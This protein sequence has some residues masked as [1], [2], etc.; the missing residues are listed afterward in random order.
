MTKVKFG[1]SEKTTKFD[2]IFVELLT[3]ASSSVYSAHVLNFTATV[4]YSKLILFLSYW[5]LSVFNWVLCY[6]KFQKSQH[7]VTDIKNGV[8]GSES[9]SESRF[10]TNL[11]NPDIPL[12]KSRLRNFINNSIFIFI[13]ISILILFSYWNILFIFYGNRTLKIIAS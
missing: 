12:P 6:L 4:L 11:W 13:S 3:S 10:W 1:F 9:R 8:F 5:N 7:W 2:K